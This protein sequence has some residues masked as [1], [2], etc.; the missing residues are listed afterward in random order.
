[1]VKQRL[2][3]DFEK[4]RLAE[5][6]EQKSIR[7]IIYKE[8]PKGWGARKKITV[9]KQVISSLKVIE[10]NSFKLDIKRHHPSY[11]KGV[12]KLEAE[13]KRL[14]YEF[15]GMSEILHI[16]DLVRDA[17][18]KAGVSIEE[19]NK[20]LSV[21]LLVAENIKPYPIEK[22]KSKNK[23]T[24]RGEFDLY[25]GNILTSQ[26]ATRRRA[27]AIIAKIREKH[28][29]IVPRQNHEKPTFVTD[30]KKEVRAI[31]QRL[32]DNGL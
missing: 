12:N 11:L 30:L 10:H 2:I 25:I 17:S 7:L 20:A 29:F 28:P 13:F 22:Q 9:A 5:R 8:L 24:A 6:M 15:E 32:R 4:M 3:L 31:E 23:T 27:S 26:G 16:N 19:I 1:M 18:N 21:F 14:I